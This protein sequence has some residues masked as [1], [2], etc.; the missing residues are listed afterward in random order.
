M[1]GAAPVIGT[2]RRHRV[3]VLINDMNATGG[4]QR[5][6]ANLVRDLRPYHDTVLLSVE[7][8]KPPVIFH[9]PGLNFQSLERRQTRFR[10][11][12]RLLHFAGTGL[13][14]R[15]WVAQ[16]QIDT[17]LAIWYDWASVAAV[18][19]PRSVKTVGC[20]HI[21][22]GEA[23]PQMRRIRRLC[24]PSLDCA[25]S[26]TR[27][28]Q[29]AL[30]RISRATRTIP[31]YVPHIQP[32]P[33]PGRERLLLTIGHLDSRKGIDRLLWG[34]KQPLHD[35]PDW[36]LVVIGGGEKGHADWGYLD[37]VAV[38]IK[39]LR[40]E[41]RVEFHPAT[42]RIDDWYRRASIYVMGS[43]REGLPM[44]LIEA[45]AH[46]VPVIAFDCPTG[47]KEIVRDGVDGF[48][49]GKDSEAFGQAAASLMTNPALHQQMSE[50][51]LADVR[52]RF[53][54]DAVLPQWRD[55]IEDLHGGR[56]HPTP[57]PTPTRIA[58]EQSGS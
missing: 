57:T 1:D 55:L 14:L 5:V 56:T 16:H 4:I 20:E 40:L 30:A 29:P 45:K 26:L 12:G 58:V 27:E 39:L 3:A 7:P 8:L 17:V 24:Y 10:R 34:L 25:V 44:V 9:E 47:P 32:A 42:S 36:R 18:A 41:G 50:A 54:A 13:A 37:Y 28:D 38:L 22:F 31:N 49:I 53:S 51:A 21:S 19:L 33:H 23:V 2:R 6:A 52:Q 35:N 43:R 48:L 11:G 46:G 15:R